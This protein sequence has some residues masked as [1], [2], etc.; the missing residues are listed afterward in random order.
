MLQDIRCGFVLQDVKCDSVT[1]CLVKMSTIMPSVT[2]LQDVRCVSVLQH[3][4]CDTVLQDVK[5]DTSIIISSMT[6]CYRMSSVT[7]VDISFH[8]QH[9]LTRDSV[10]INAAN[11][12]LKTLKD[13]AC[14][15]IDTK[16]SSVTRLWT[17]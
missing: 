2:L 1:E 11:L 9:G 14:N 6:L 12:T 5:C 8:L 4:K 16:V 7:G 10:T 17:A 13:E 3:V 15:F